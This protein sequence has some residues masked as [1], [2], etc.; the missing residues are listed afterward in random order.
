MK[1]KRSFELVVAPSPR[2]DPAADLLLVKCQMRQN[3]DDITPLVPAVSGL[4]PYDILVVRYSNSTRTFSLFAKY[5]APHGA[6]KCL[7][8]QP[9][10]S[11]PLPPPPL[12]C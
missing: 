12:R 9:L 7:H 5:K 10:E 3:T 6:Q 11:A 1:E 8:V 2:I 4:I